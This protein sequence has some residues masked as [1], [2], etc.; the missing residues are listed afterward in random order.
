MKSI[1]TLMAEAEYAATALKEA[2]AA[3]HADEI[4]HADYRLAYQDDKAARRALRIREIE[5]YFSK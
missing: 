2:E 5:G 4:D 1:E 3:Y